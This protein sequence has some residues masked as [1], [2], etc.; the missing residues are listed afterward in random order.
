M[1]RV[2]VYPSARLTARAAGVR[3]LLTIVD[4][5]SVTAPVHISLTG[6]SLGIEMLRAIAGEELL[7]AV[8]WSQ[9]HIWWGDE[10]FA[11]DA[12]RNATAAREA[13]LDS[14]PL[15]EANIHEVVRPADASD[16]DDA[17]RRYAEQVRGIHFTVMVLGVG[18]DG[19]VASLFPGRREVDADG[20]G[21]LPVRHS[22]KLPPERVT[23]TRESLSDADEVW[24]LAAGEEKAEKIAESV[25]PRGTMLPAAR[26]RG[27]RTLWLLDTAAASR[28]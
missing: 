22:P 6:G 28:L 14:L 13:L 7:D 4:A 23:L 26:V 1:E 18:P 11:A 15:P 5:Q 10:R 12:D 9:V 16:V 24:F 21:A 25:R 27:T 3:L 8:D 20:R 17:A 2:L 19:H